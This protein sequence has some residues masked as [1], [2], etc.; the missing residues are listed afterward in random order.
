MRA[1]D[2]MAV[3]VAKSNFDGHEYSA[4]VIPNKS[5][6]PVVDGVPGPTFKIGDIAA[7]DMRSYPLL[8]KIT[9]IS[10]THIDFEPNEDE[11]SPDY[12]P[13][14]IKVSDFIVYNYEFDLA[15]AKAKNAEYGVAF[16][17]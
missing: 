16:K 11:A 7:W 9:H 3:E 8:G 14:L 13:E 6:Q 1:K 15:A 12:G 5:I 17:L 4:M 10:K 2:I